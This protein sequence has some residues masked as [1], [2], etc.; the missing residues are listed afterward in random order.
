LSARVAQARLDHRFSPAFRSDLTLRWYENLELQNYHEPRGLLDT[1]GDGIHDYSMREFR[2][3][4]RDNDA[5]SLTVNNVFNF[6]AIGAQHTL[7]FGADALRQDGV[8]HGRTAE[9]FEDGGVVPGLSLVNPVY[10]QTSA[11]AYDLA[12]IPLRF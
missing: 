1:D 3:Q 9:E 6:R 12:S 11:A 7:L 5:A 2:D 4:R 8:F 10:G